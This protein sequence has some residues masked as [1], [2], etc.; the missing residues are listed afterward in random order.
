MKKWLPFGITFGIALAAAAAVWAWKHSEIG[1]LEKAARPAAAARAR[2]SV[3]SPR[4]EVAAKSGNKPEQAKIDAAVRP[5]RNGIRSLFERAAH[6]MEMDQE[7]LEKLIAELETNGRIRSPIAGINLL[8]AYA[9]LAEIDPAGAMERAKN[10]KGELR[11]MAM[12]ATMNEWLSRDRKAA[13]SWFAQ[14]KDDEAKR[15]YLT[16]AAFGMGG[17]DPELIAELSTAINDPDARKKAL[18]DSISALAFSDPDAAMKK[19]DEIEDPDQREEAE[20]RVYQGYLMRYPEKALDF[21]FTKPPGDK[22]RDNARR[23]LV[24]WGD[25]D[26]GAAL[27]WLTSQNKEIQKELFD[28]GDK[29]P[30]WGFGKAT[31]QQINDAAVKLADQSQRDKLHAAYANSQGW[32]DPKAGL[33]Q[34]GSIKDTELQMKTAEALGASAARAGKTSDMEQWLETAQPNDAR[35]T[36][37]ASFATGLAQKDAAK[38]LEWAA[39]ITNAAIR[40]RTIEALKATPA[41]KP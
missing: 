39:K 3:L 34:L 8:A 32:S 20:E 41:P 40:T 24:Q 10:A 11:D 16:M 31:P 12:F 30:G 23:A 36:A 15:K 7:D 25:Q 28:T 13:V 5:T 9:R 4:K 2:G 19:L 18:L 29:G 35:D 14:S 21:A 1:D 22:A 37:V 6:I 38:G 27:N 33:S 26:A 17:G